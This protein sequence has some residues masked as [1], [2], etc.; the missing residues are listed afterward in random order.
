MTNQL[1]DVRLA[2]LD[3]DGVVNRKLGED[4][5]IVTWEQFEFMPNAPEAI[6]KLN[7]AGIKVVVVTNQR[8][9]SELIMLTSTESFLSARRQFL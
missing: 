9:R 5:Y 3:R 2:F 7:R 1:T 4:N 6:A 8:G